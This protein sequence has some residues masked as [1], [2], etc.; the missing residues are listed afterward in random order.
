MDMARIVKINL[1]DSDGNCS[2]VYP[3]LSNFPTATH[4]RAWAEIQVY[5]GF[6]ATE[7][8]R[9]THHTTLRYVFNPVNLT[10]AC[11]VFSRRVQHFVE[12]RP[13]PHWIDAIMRADVEWIATHGAS[14]RFQFQDDQWQS[15]HEQAYEMFIA[16]GSRLLVVPLLERLSAGP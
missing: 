5:G 14:R 11:N 2:Q 10:G 16:P 6:R 9:V 12:P 1:R 4:F 7:Y 13:G 3:N 15:L 8:H